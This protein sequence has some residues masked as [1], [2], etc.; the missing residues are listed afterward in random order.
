[1]IKTESQ[2]RHKIKQVMF[3]HRKKFIQ[4]HMKNTPDRC[5]FNQMLNLGTGSVQICRKVNPSIICMDTQQS[6]NCTLYASTSEVDV[7]Q[8]KELFYQSVIDRS[9]RPS[10]FTAHYPDAA[11]LIWALGMTSREYYSPD[12]TEDITSEI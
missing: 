7:Q 10:E 5:K 12:S 11:A 1:M 2:I 4:R 8:L 6:S 9:Q 3:R